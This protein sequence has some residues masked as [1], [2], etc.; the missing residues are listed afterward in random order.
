MLII[1]ILYT[2]WQSILSLSQLFE[3]TREKVV[4]LLLAMP[5]KVTIQKSNS[6]GRLVLE[7]VTKVANHD[8]RKDGLPRSGNAWTKQGLLIGP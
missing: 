3:K 8:R 2:C 7:S 5:S 6:D 4:N 1:E